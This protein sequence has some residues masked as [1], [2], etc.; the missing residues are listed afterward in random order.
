M[1]AF[2]LLVSALAACFA[3]I[4]CRIAGF[5]SRDEERFHYIDHARAYLRGDVR[6]PGCGEMF[7][8][9]HR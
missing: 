6:C 8:E 9:V 5:G 3:W 7:H 1:F 2:W 4:L